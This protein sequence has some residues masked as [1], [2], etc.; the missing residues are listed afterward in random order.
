MFNL[1]VDCLDQFNIGRVTEILVR[2]G[3]YI[4]LLRVL[5]IEPAYFVS[6]SKLTSAYLVTLKLPLVYVTS[7]QSKTFVHFN[8]SI[9]FVI[10]PSETIH[11]KIK[12]KCT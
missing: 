8:R 12:I 7:F 4:L 1:V 5:K 3:R 10:D 9:G 6:S 2:C 11:Q